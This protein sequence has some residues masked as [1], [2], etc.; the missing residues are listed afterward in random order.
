V[1]LRPLIIAALFLPLPGCTVLGK[2]GQVLMDPSI[3]VGAASDQPTQVAFSLYASPTLNGNPR[4]LDAPVADAVLE[5]SPYA[6]SLTAGNPQV[7]TEKV[8]V[9][10]AYLQE[11]FP[12]VSPI[13]QEQEQPTLPRSSMEDSSPGTYDDPEVHLSLAQPQ[14]VS[15]E[16]IATPIAIKIFQLRDDSLLHNTV[17]SGLEQEPAKAL[18]ST[19]IRDDDYLLT[20]GQFKFVPFEA[21]DADTRFIAVIANYSNQ[22]DATWKQVLRVQPRGRKVVLA[23]QINDSQILLKEES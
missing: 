14:M 17:Y 7:L 6:V 1:K 19:Y 5:P 21:I 18:R 16:Q 3:P 12:A 2:V 23:V 13:E 11:Q 4:S 9:L 8:E 22:Q 10:L 15:A 20:P